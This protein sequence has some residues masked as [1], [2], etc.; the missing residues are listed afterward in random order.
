MLHK[1]S[2]EDKDQ[3]YQGEVLPDS[4]IKHGE[5]TLLNKKEMYKYV[6]SFKFGKKDGEAGQIEY[7]DED[8]EI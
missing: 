2:L 7:I 6:G 5:G 4:N 1:V 3:Y 8:A